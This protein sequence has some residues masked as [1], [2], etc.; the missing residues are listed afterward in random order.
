MSGGLYPPIP[1][2]VKNDAD[3]SWDM[4][5]EKFPYYQNLPSINPYC[6]RMLKQ[7]YRGD[8]VAFED[9][10]TSTTQVATYLDKCER[11]F[12]NIQCGVL[13][14]ATYYYVNY[15]MGFQGSHQVSPGQIAEKPYDTVPYY[16]EVAPVM[17]NQ[18]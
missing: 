13:A 10:C 2:G 6:C 15:G 3:S 17:D 8:V 18:K 1:S 7:S 16:L 4:C 5:M 14:E 9:F 11:K 12:T